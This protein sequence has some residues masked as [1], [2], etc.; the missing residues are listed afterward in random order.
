MTHRR[1]RIERL[2]PLQL[3]GYWRMTSAERIEAAFST[4]ELLRELITGHVRGFHPDRDE[5]QVRTA[6]ADRFVGHTS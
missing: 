3:E 6:V 4:N 2:H 1:P 5:E